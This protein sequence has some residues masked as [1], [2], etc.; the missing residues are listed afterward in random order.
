MSQSMAMDT[1]VRAPGMQLFGMV[2][3]LA[4]CQRRWFWGLQLAMEIQGEV[5]GHHDNS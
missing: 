1:S 2:R 5:E 4:F 3:K